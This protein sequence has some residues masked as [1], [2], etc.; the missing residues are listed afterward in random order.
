MDVK[1]VALSNCNN[2]MGI[3]V[4]T[5]LSVPGKV[6]NRVLLNRM[7][8]A[9]DPELKYEQRA[10]RIPTDQIAPL[11]IIIEQ[12]IEWNSPLY[13]NFIDYEKSFDSVDRDIFWKLLRHYAI[14]TKI[15]NLIK[16]T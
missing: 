6:L 9:L 4:I 8:N 10:S 5:L 12:S 16:N 7:R 13:V 3:T 1:K 15:V 11:R 14:P 2:Y